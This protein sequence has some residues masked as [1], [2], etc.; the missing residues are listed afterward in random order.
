[1]GKV[2]IPFFAVLV[3]SLGFMGC[4]TVKGEVD[5]PFAN[6]EWR[7]DDGTPFMQASYI[8]FDDAGNVECLIHG[9]SGYDTY[10]VTKKGESYN[11]EFKA[12]HW[13]MG[14]VDFTISKK[15]AEEGVA[16]F[17]SQKRLFRKVNQTK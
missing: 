13:V 12:S 4:Q 7:A 15:D 1:M 16:D 17:M 8:K 2:L 14:N 5:D 9:Q 10:E 3:L 6:T 11:A